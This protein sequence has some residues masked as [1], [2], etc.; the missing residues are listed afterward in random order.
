MKENTKDVLVREG[1]QVPV[2]IN[3]HV[4]EVDDDVYDYDDDE[5][6]CSIYFLLI[7][8]FHEALVEAR[9]SFLLTRPLPSSHSH[10]FI[11]FFFTPCLS[12]YI[13]LCFLM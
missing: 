3:D 5:C 4:D 11:V 9:I 7:I 6:I 1:E 10:S 13:S 8:I 2:C 12:I